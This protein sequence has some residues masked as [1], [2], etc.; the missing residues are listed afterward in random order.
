MKK[1]NLYF[2]KRPEKDRWI[3][4][5]HYV[6]PFIRRLV[7]GKKI[8]GVEKVFINLCKGFDELK[9]A[10]TV[11]KPFKQIG[12]D[13]AVIVLGVGKY[14]L[15]GYDQPN[16]IIGGIGMM[17]HP[18]EW[19]DLCE[20][21]PVVKY[22]Q[23]SE[24]ARDIFTRYYGAEIC[25]LWPA[26]IETDKWAPE[27]TGG[28]KYDFLVYDKIMWDQEKTRQQLKA[29]VLEKLRERNLSY[30]MISYG[31]YKENEYRELLAQSRAMLFLCEHESQG[32]ACCEALS[33]DVPVLAW[34]QGQ[35]LD[36]A[37]IKLED[38]IVPATSVPFFDASCG[39]TF[40]GYADFEDKLKL[41]LENLQDG[42][43]NPRN[44]IL[45]NITLKM[46]AERMLELINE[47]YG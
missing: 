17:T 13:E 4:G 11:N 16:R 41:F 6:I 32:F 18:T 44:F 25:A 31:H 3:P 47:V 29:P 37:R 7:R 34:D 1:I 38:R 46:S 2:R 39:M 21:Y 28:K 5:D 27:N 43:Y 12:P 23:H 14:S 40:A 10:Y 8:G 35:W 45:E 33:M 20:K 19:P 22:L 24:W 9:V 15:E 36:P 42:A 26:G 30:A